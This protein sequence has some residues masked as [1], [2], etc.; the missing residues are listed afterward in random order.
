MTQ[1][2]AIEYALVVEEADPFAVR[3]TEQREAIETT[4]PL[5][6]REREVATLIA[7][8]LTNRRI[9]EELSISERTVTTHLG[10]ILNKLEI[11]S[12]EEVANRIS[13]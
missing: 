6:H 4:V 2:E 13:D 5:T 3:A 12:R 11:Q 10:R 1:E 9:A 8:G 7:R